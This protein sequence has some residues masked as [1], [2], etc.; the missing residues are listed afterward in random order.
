MQDLAGL[1]QCLIC[2]L[3]FFF[4]SPPFFYL[5]VSR[6]VM[7]LRLKE[8]EAGWATQKALDGSSMSQGD[9]DRKIVHVP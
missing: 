9:D 6:Y 4:L 8:C 3:L 1:G 5:V 7:E 2:I